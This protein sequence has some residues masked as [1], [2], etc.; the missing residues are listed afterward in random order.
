MDNCKFIIIAAIN[1]DGIIGVNNEIPWKIPEDFKHF[2]NTT[3]GNILIVGKNTY[4][5]LPDKAFEG[6]EYIVLSK[7]EVDHDNRPNVYKF[8]KLDII[9]DL[10]YNNDNA[11]NKVFIAGGEMIYNLLIDY[12]DE[13][14]ITWVNVD[15]N[16]SNNNIKMFPINKLFTNF[17]VEGNN[18]WQVSKTDIEYR[19][20]N[21]K[22]KK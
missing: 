8:S 21:Y 11:I 6:R 1:I 2:R 5:S 17:V 3:M 4:L 16:K 15:I 12:C 9:F 20:V 13:A 10:I 22:R 18:S 19:I 7:N 14:V